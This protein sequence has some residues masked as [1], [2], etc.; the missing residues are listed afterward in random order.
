MS[1]QK[2]G[3]F[4][5][6][7]EELKMK[8]QKIQEGTAGFT[9]QSAVFLLK[10]LFLIIPFVAHRNLLRQTFKIITRYFLNPSKIIYK[11]S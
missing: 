7:A 8:I 4:D 11:L 2:G 9:N 3:L 6:T 10:M 1:K 5:N